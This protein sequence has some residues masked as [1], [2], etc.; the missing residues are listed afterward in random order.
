MAAASTIVQNQIP[1]RR[2]SS[3]LL[4]SPFSP[5]SPVSV[6]LFNGGKFYRCHGVLEEMWYSAEE[7]IRTLIH[8]ILLCAVGLHHLLNQNHRGAMI[9]LGEGLCK[10][11]NSE[12]TKRTL[13]AYSLSL[14]SDAKTH[15]LFSA[16]NHYSS[17]RPSRV[18]A[19]ILGATE[20][21]LIVLRY[22][23]KSDGIFASS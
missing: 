18:K 11:R 6:N 13:L 4:L 5:L 3:S 17:E 23:S 21:H 1:S 22:I 15:I 12:F 8:G 14:G 10:L 20:K 9:Q 2:L 7:P 19:P 16:P